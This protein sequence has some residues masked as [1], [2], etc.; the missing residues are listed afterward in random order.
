MTYYSVYVKM[1]ESRWSLLLH[2]LIIQL[3]WKE[4]IICMNST[5]DSFPDGCI[6]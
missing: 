1:Q 3:M 4:L 6:T 2:R 5:A